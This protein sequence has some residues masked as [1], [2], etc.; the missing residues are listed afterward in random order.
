MDVIRI[1]LLVPVLAADAIVLLLGGKRLGRHISEAVARADEA[2]AA[3]R[4]ERRRQGQPR[5][6][7]SHPS[8]A[9]FRKAMR[10]AGSKTTRI[11]GVDVDGLTVTVHFMSRSGLTDY[12]ARYKFERYDEADDC[13]YPSINYQYDNGDFEPRTKVHQAFA[14]NAA[15]ELKKYGCTY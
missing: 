14:R 3:A 1:L 6:F 4:E 8:E 10:D 7:R 11:Q 9:E 5:R 12:W 2:A 13:W 15:T